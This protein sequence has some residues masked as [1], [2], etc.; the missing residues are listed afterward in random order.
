MTRLG[1]TDSGTNYFKLVNASETDATGLLTTAQAKTYTSSLASG[2]VVLVQSEVRLLGVANTALTAT[3]DLK[4]GGTIIDTVVI[5]YPATGAGDIFETCAN[6]QATRTTAGANEV[7]D[8]DVTINAGT[9]G[10]WTV[11]S[12]R[13]FEI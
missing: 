7:F 5:Q 1:A 4:A 8:V 12:L 6:L 13:V 10:L 2:A 9:A 11:R 3:F